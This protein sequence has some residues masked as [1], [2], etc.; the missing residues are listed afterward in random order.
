[1]TTHCTR[2]L[3]VLALIVPGGTLL[4]AADPEPVRTTGQVLVLVNERTLEGSIERHGDQYCVRRSIGE[5]W[6]P[7]DQVLYLCADMEDAYTRLRQRANLRDPD[8]RLRLTRW[9]L[10]HGLKSQ[11]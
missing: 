9:C 4:R 8:E 7:S 2:T 5:T 6:L 1:M 3:C 10:L 11:A